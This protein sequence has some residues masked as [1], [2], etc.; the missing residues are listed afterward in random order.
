VD[1]QQIARWTDS[2]AGDYQYMSW[3]DA[4]YVQFDELCKWIHEQRQTRLNKKLE[5]MYLARSHTLLVGG[6]LHSRRLGGLVE[7]NVE[8]YNKLGSEEEDESILV[9][10]NY[11]LL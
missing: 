8:V 9:D 5:L 10:L 3:A 4:A 11:C 7:T 1:W 6:G 2:K